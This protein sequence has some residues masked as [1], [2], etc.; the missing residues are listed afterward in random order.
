[1]IRT[2][3]LLILL[4]SL[5]MLKNVLCHFAIKGTLMKPQKQVKNKRIQII[6]WRGEM[7]NENLGRV[8][9]LKSSTNLSLTFW[10]GKTKWILK[11]SVSMVILKEI[12]HQKRLSYFLHWSLTITFYIAVHVLAWHNRMKNLQQKHP[13]RFRNVLWLL[14]Q[15]L[16]FN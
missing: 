15:K 9:Q 2:N 13:K 14:L 3:H 5:L 10:N 7:L 8:S 1:M 16:S 6:K 12:L 11:G 4:Y